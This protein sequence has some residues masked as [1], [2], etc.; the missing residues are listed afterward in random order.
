MGITKILVKYG[1]KASNRVFDTLIPLP[2]CPDACMESVGI[3]DFSD[4]DDGWDEDFS[5]LLEH[6]ADGEEFSLVTWYPQ[7]GLSEILELPRISD[8]MNCLAMDDQTHFTI[9][10]G[11]RRITF[12][13]GHQI[14]WLER[15]SQ[16]RIVSLPFQIEIT[17]NDR[18]A[19][20]F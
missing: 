14:L 4:D 9:A 15:F 17:D 12:T 20:L 19:E 1:V 10:M 13:R 2:A 5:S 7:T 3:D 16:D 11:P 18:I 6:L 8:I